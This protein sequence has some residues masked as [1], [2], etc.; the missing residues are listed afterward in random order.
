M[1]P[2]MA[3]GYGHFI[4]EAH[5]RAVLSNAQPAGDWYI[6]TI[7]FH[8]TGHRSPIHV[9]VRLATLNRAPCTTSAWQEL[10]CSL[11]ELR[12][13]SA[14]IQQ[15]RPPRLQM[16]G[17]PSSNTRPRSDAQAGHNGGER[18]SFLELLWSC[19]TELTADSAETLAAQGK[20]ACPVCLET[21]KAGDEYVCLPCDGE[22]GGHWRCLKPWLEAKS[23]CPCCRYDFPT[24]QQQAD[25]GELMA[26]SLTAISKLKTVT[27]A[28]L[29]TRLARADSPSSTATAEP[30]PSTSQSVQPRRRAASPLSSSQK[31]ASLEAAAKAG[32]SRALRQLVAMDGHDTAKMSVGAALRRAIE[33]HNLAVAS[34]SSTP[35]SSG[36][37][38][39][40]QPPPGAP[41]PPPGPNPQTAL[42][43]H[44]PTAAVA[45]WTQEGGT[46]PP[47]Y[48][49]SIEGAA[50]SGS[51][52]S[53]RNRVSYSAGYALG[54][55]LRKIGII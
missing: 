49:V 6:S 9:M 22:H 27:Q 42:H 19:S 39:H 50:R 25:N 5:L 40:P 29:K 34:S 45:P 2:A 4:A 23:N 11:S 10:D 26:R 41:P 1:L 53:I 20:D 51:G 30:G 47:L 8:D 46:P 14:R 44:S 31:R 16:H 37:P 21:F 35:S 32:S 36:R 54:F 28:R 13:A 24:G 38:L 33:V 52:G 48:P 7:W 18:S 43:P 17:P 55:A 12:T 15:S 3:D